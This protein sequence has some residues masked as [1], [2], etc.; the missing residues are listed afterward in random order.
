MLKRG[1][2]TG[3]TL[4]ELLVTLAIV[5]LAASAVAGVYQVSHQTYIR[6]SSLE[7]AQAGARAGLDRMANDLRL[8]GSCWFGATGA[9]NAI[10]AATPTSIIFM[11]NVDDL[12]VINGT[13]ATTTGPVTGNGASVSLTTEQTD[14]AF[15]TYLPPNQS[16]NDYIYI[17]DGGRR[18]VQQIIQKNGSALTLASALTLTPP[19]YPTGSLVRNVKRITYARN[20]GTNTPLTRTQGGSGADTIVDNVSALTFTYFG[21]DGVASLGTNPNTAFIREIQVDLT[22]QG[23]DGSPRRMTTRVR[24][25]SLP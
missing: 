5:G 19:A 7:D 9:G 2:K 12:S 6:A 20:P 11:A 22:V 10:I 14:V 25:R 21:T 4:A 13:E 8:I 23:A 3:Y 17:A 18:E 24:P 1:N 15:R 16:L